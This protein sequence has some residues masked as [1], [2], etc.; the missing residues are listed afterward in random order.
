[1]TL[2]EPASSLTDFA[3]GILA[4]FAATRLHVKPSNDSHWRWFFIWIGIAALWGGV[5]HGFIAANES[6]AAI[7]WSMISLLVAVAISYLLAASANAVIGKKRGR[8]LFVFRAISLVAFFSL[9]VSGNATVTTLML[10]EGLA[11]VIVVGL[12]IHA[13]QSGQPGGSLVL[14]AIAVS[15]L[16]AALKASGAQ[17]TFSGWEFDPNSIYHV[18][19]MPGLCLLLM[20]VQRRSAAMAAGPVLSGDGVALPV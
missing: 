17:F 11:M 5:H 13:W 15:V 19:Q 14:G 18:A 3:L 8:P 20:A 7:S 4:I 12:W 16:A 6:A 9:A 1:M 2:V 10:T